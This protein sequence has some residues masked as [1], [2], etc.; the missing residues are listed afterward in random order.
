MGQFEAE[1]ISG[2]IV[3]YFVVLYALALINLALLVYLV[4]QVSVLGRVRQMS[5]APTGPSQGHD[6]G[7]KQN[8]FKKP[9]TSSKIRPKFVSETREAEI[10]HRLSAEAERR[11]PIYR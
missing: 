8:Q 1:S 3:I 2:F 6:H 10:A 5:P 11:D 7:D 4:R 9:H